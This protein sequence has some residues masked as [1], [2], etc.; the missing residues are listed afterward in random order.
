LGWTA[1]SG[2]TGDELKAEQIDF[3]GS[4]PESVGELKTFGELGFGFSEGWQGK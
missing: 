2:A 1:K 4:S 3:T